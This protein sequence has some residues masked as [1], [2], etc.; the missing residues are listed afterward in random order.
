M[1]RHIKRRFHELSVPKLQEM[2]TDTMFASAR[3]YEGYKAA[4]MYAG[5]KA[6]RKEVYGLRTNS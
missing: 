4:Q 5:G 6:V 2:S 1:R 3:S